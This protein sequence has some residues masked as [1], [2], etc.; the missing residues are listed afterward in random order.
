M[1]VRELIE[2]LEELNQDYEVKTWNNYEIVPIE[3]ATEVDAPDYG[4]EEDIVLLYQN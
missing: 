4:L 3:M 1:T 2:Q